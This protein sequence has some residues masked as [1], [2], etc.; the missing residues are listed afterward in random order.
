MIGI[1]SRKRQLVIFVVVHGLVVVV[2]AQGAC[3]LDKDDNEMHQ[4]A[5]RTCSACKTTAFSHEI[6]R[7]VG[8]SF[9]QSLT[10]KGLIIRQPKHNRS[11]V[12]F[13]T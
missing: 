2:V 9:S 10:F 1:L 13:K 5:K 6:C 4:N 8:V 11:T 3:C 7:F 12:Y